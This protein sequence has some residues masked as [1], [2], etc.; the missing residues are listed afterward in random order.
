LGWL[1]LDDPQIPPK[2]VPFEGVN[3]PATQSSRDKPR[4]GLHS[5]SS[6]PGNQSRTEF[7][8]T[9][10]GSYGR[11]GLILRAFTLYLPSYAISRGLFKTRPTR[12]FLLVL[13]GRLH[14]RAGEF[15]K[16]HHP[17]FYALTKNRREGTKGT[18]SPIF[19]S[20]HRCG[21]CARCNGDCSNWP[22][23]ASGRAMCGRSTGQSAGP[24]ATAGAFVRTSC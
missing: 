7:Y 24:Q 23:H 19:K 15:S 17:I 9:S 8:S 13:T 11:G 16:F 6:H 12:P 5:L 18:V 3:L 21:W 2:R 14:V 4:I 10:V 20:S 1:D 22:H